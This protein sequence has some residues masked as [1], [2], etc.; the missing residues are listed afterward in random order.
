MT[1]RLTSSA[2]GARI[3]LPQPASPEHRHT[4][5]QDEGIHPNAQS[6]EPCPPSRVRDEPFTCSVREVPA[7][8]K[9]VCV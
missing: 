2:P 3:P 8:V 4:A 6:G 1:I 7:H 5:P 9:S